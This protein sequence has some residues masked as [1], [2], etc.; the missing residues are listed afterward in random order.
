MVLLEPFEHADV[1]ESERASAFQRHANPQSPSWPFLGSCRGRNGRG[2]SRG[3]KVWHRRCAW[4][5]HLCEGGEGNQQ[6][7]ETRECARHDRLLGLASS[8]MDAGAN[9]EFVLLVWTRTSG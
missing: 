4:R 1:S 7:Q 3:N 5:R 2:F 8:S 6:H 9:S